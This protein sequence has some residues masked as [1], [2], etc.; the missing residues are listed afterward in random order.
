MLEHLLGFARRSPASD[1]HNPACEPLSSLATAHHPAQRP[2][3]ALAQGFRSHATLAL[4]EA[5]RCLGQAPIMSA[6]QSSTPQFVD[7][8]LVVLTT[9]DVPA[10]F[11]FR[12]RCLLLSPSVPSAMIG[13][14][15]KRSPCLGASCTNAWVDSAVMSRQ[16]ALIEFDADVKRV[17]IKDIGSLHGTF[18]NGTILDSDQSQRLEQGDILK[19]GISVERSAQT[20]PPCVMKVTLNHGTEPRPD[21]KPVIFRVPDDD[22]DLDDVVSDDDFSI[23]NSVRILRENGVRP[24]KADQVAGSI[25]LTSDDGDAAEQDGSSKPQEK[26]TTTGDDTWTSTRQGQMETPP[27]D[28]NGRERQRS[29]AQ[30]WQE[31]LGHDRGLLGQDSSPAPGVD[32]GKASDQAPSLDDGLGVG[33]A[34]EWDGYGSVPSISAAP[35]RTTAVWPPW[36]GRLITNRPLPMTARRR[37]SNQVMGL[38]LAKSRRL[39]QPVCPVL[40][41]GATMRSRSN[42]RMAG[43]LVRRKRL[44]GSRA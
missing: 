19:F 9:L 28:D 21:G 8:V 11:P 27:A 18:H 1:W 14:T 13:R 26:D 2:R 39:G 15:S 4:V 25:D 34:D 32:V 33:D 3:S 7:E 30:E 16:H 42:P 31:M 5:L 17:F 44:K 29:K 20:F 6:P 23:R 22:S 40:L 10:T 36:P 37:N 35:P 43:G 38:G 12:D 24:A 41:V